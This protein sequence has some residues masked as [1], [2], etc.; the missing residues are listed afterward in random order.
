MRASA[1]DHAE[2]NGAYAASN[3]PHELLM[4]D[5]LF[6]LRVKV[7]DDRVLFAEVV[8]LNAAGHNDHH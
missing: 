7:L 1:M 4:E 6:L 3:I 8:V 2:E 5:V